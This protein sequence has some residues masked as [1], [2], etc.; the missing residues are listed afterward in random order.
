MALPPGLLPE[1]AD[2]RSSRAPLVL[3]TVVCAAL[4][5]VLGLLIQNRKLAGERDRAVDALV[6][7]RKGVPAPPPPAPVAV[8]PAPPTPDPEP[9]AP[10]G[11]P[12]AVARTRAPE[13]GG[14]PPRPEEPQYISRGLQDFR[15]GRYDQ[16]ERQFFRAL[17]DSLLYLSL[18]SLAER[19][20]REAFSFLSRAMSADPRWLRRVNPRDLFGN[21]ADYDAL[22]QALEEQ[23]SKTPTDPDLKTLAA[24]VRFHEKGAPYAK[25]LL[26]E[27]T[28][29]DPDHEAARRFLEALGP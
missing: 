2:A 19:N 24:Y 26:I 13:E 17:P 25:A 6:R 27:A 14:S 11:T 4:V 10:S 1:T 28:T 3:A 18:T 12:N 9:P 7:E 20:W 22:I 21:P 16:A 8:A 15:S 29:V 23:L 5:A